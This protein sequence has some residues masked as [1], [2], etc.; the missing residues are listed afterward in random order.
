MARRGWF[1]KNMIADGFKIRRIREPT[2]F[3]YLVLRGIHTFFKF[4][5]VAEEIGSV[6]VAYMIFVDILALI[7]I[8]SYCTFPFSSNIDQVMALGWPRTSMTPAGIVGFIVIS[9]VDRGLL[10]GEFLLGPVEFIFSAR[11]RC[12]DCRGCSGC[13]GCRGC[14]GCWDC[15]DWACC[16][17]HGGH[18]HFIDVSNILKHHISKYP[19]VI[20]N[21][22]YLSYYATVTERDR[23]LR[24]W[25]AIAIDYVRLIEKRLPKSA[26]IPYIFR[27]LK[28]FASRTQY[29]AFP[30][31][32]RL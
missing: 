25:Y 7:D 3:R 6:R 5:F 13:G 29:S 16:S 30:W 19:K 26:L 22:G 9:L 15:R 2:K 4:G 28:P 8:K 10:E 11:G 21:R 14:R 24:L 20:W 31:S 32:I 27:Q 12:R 17:L 1:N 18:G 23:H